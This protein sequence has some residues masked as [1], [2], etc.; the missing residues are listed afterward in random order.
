[1]SKAQTVFTM[2]TANTLPHLT[3]DDMLAATGLSHQRYRNWLKDNNKPLYA[4]T[5]GLSKEVVDLDE[6]R[7]ALRQ[8]YHLSTMEL[9]ACLYSSTAAVNHMMKKERAALLRKHGAT[10]LDILNEG[11]PTDTTSLSKEITA[12]RKDGES[13]QWLAELYGYTTGRISQLDKNTKRK[14]RLSPKEKE[15]I[16]ASS[17]SPAALA[18]RYQTTINTIYVTRREK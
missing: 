7:V 10:E 15:E 3:I 5:P 8:Q 16:R 9:N 6:S 12:R 4:P 14:N 1:M 18:K 2:Y 17:E 13:V 11:L